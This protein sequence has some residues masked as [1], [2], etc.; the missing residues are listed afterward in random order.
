M[1]VHF[2][3]YRHLNYLNNNLFDFY[4][5]LYYIFVRSTLY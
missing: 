4:S 3:E 1:S 5:S 2:N